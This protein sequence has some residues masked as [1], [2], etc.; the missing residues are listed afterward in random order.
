MYPEDIEQLFYLVEPQ[1]PVRIVN[2]PFKAGF[3]NNHLYLEAH[4]T[5]L[6]NRGTIQERVEKV[7]NLLM[8]LTN[9]DKEQI[10]WSSVEAA[11][12]TQSGIPTVVSQ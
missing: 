12:I 4:K 3:D 8:S 9:N 10:N 7:Y 1:I 6:E 11:L 5:L 2:E